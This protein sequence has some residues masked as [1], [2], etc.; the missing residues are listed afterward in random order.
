MENINHDELGIYSS[1][2]K[3]SRNFVQRLTS[4][5][6]YLFLQPK[7]ILI[8]DIIWVLVGIGAV[9]WA[10]RHTGSILFSII[11]SIV[12]LGVSLAYSHFLPRFYIWFSAVFFGKPVF[13]KLG[14]LDRLSFFTL[15]KSTPKMRID[16]KESEKELADRF[17]ELDNEL[18]E[19]LFKERYYALYG[20]QAGKD[21]TDIEAQWKALWENKM[22]IV[23]TGKQTFQ[24]IRN[25]E[26]LAF[27]IM[28]MK[29]QYA[30][31]LI[32]PF[33]KFFQLFGICLIVAYLANWVALLTVIQVMVALNLILSIFWY[34]L[35]SYNMSEIALLVPDESIISPNIFRQFAEKIK[36]LQSIT[37]KP[38]NITIE[39]SFFA[40]IRSYQLRFIGAFTLLNSLYILG[41]LLIVMGAHALLIGGLVGASLNWYLSFALG[42]LLLP[43]AFYIGFYFISVIIQHFRKVLGSLVVG[44]T[45]AVLP[46][47]IYYLI[48]GQ[49][50]INEVQNGIWAALSGITTILSTIVASQF[51][52]ILESEPKKDSDKK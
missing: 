26:N 9:T 48:K 17:C 39:N 4:V 22:L 5:Y 18:T 15:L 42:A 36:A 3:T 23:G 28:P 37:L 43:V 52:E 12:L 41:L 31:M 51:R 47:F 7:A 16:L 27:R 49:L 24:S 19:A 21:G 10:F 20:E 14:G 32:S 33:I 40:D 30:S 34:L 25:P 13:G 45:T 1:A 29:L 38:L 6:Q 35:Y 46:F 11:V 44:V 2:P 8:G 50:Q